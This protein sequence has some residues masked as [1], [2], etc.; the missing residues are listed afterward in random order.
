MSE[1]SAAVYAL[2]TARLAAQAFA[3]SAP[4]HALEDARTRWHQ[5]TEFDVIY[6]DPM[7]GRHPKTAQPAKH[8]QVLAEI[9]DEVADIATWINDARGVAAARVVVKRRASAKP[10]FSPDWCIV[11]RSVRF[12][13]YRPLAS[14]PSA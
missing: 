10:I 7:F 3:D 9:A 5:R 11:G 4:T 14:T 6:L 12:D 13:V 2:L 1:H 8:M